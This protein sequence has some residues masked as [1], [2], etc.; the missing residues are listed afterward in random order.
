MQSHALP[1]AAESERERDKAWIQMRTL[2]LN[3]ETKDARDTYRTHA[4]SALSSVHG[5]QVCPVALTQ[6]V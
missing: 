5:V 3:D 4:A 6:Q 1:G 2:A